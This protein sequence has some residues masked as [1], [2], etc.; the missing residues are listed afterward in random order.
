[1]ARQA[2]RP[3]AVSVK[4]VVQDPPAAAPAL[5][6]YGAGSLW[7]FVNIRARCREDK[8]CESLHWLA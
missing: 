3:A 5:K 2:A 6:P 4:A 8:D 7:T 1:M